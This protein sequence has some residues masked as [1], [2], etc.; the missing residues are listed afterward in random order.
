[1]KTSNENGNLRAYHIPAVTGLFVCLA[2]CAGSPVHTSSLSYYEIASS[3]L[4]TLRKFAE[5]LRG[6]AIENG[7]Y[8][9]IRQ[10]SHN[11]V[12]AK[13]LV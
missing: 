3:A 7:N 2:S 10:S 6:W 8:E 13:S 5:Q 12:R 11:L 1:M 4:P 9:V